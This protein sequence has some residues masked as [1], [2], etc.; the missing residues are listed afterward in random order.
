MFDRTIQSIERI[1]KDTRAFSFYATLITQCFFVL[2]YIG[3]MLLHLGVIPI[4]ITLLTLTFA[5][6]VFFLCT[7]TPTEIRPIK[8]RR[9]IRISIRYAKYCVHLVAVSMAIYSLYTT[10]A[11]PSPFSIILLI[12]A[13]LAFLIQVI[14]E[15]LGFVCRKYFED[16]KT[17]A[18]ADTELLRSFLGKVQGGFDAYKNAKDGLANIPEKAAIIGSG[19]KDKIAHFFSK[20]D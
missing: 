5:A 2:Y 3:A 8:M 1:Q 9:W 14:G 19:L 10:T 16:L 7:E 4:H 13:I 18:L 17:A 20:K 12:L 6:L 11:V 15:L